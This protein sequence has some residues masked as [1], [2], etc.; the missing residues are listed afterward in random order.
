MCLGGGQKCALTPPREEQARNLWQQRG[1]CGVYTYQN[2]G[3]LCNR[4]SQCYLLPI[5][6][7]MFVRRK[8]RRRGFGTKMLQDYCRRFAKEVILGISCPIS[9]AMYQV[10]HKFFLHRPEEQDRLWEVE[11]PGDWCQRV[12]IWLRIQLGEAPEDPKLN[13]RRRRRSQSEL[14]E[15]SVAKQ[16]K[17]S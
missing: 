7:T 13:R 12:N 5:L 8:W 17:T 3:S 6:D 4:S 2:K 1:G 9:P 11:A 14:V 16:M 15:E 10:C